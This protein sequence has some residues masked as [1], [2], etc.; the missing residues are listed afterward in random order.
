MSR[1]VIDLTSP[2]SA[3]PAGPRLHG[4]FFGRQGKGYAIS[5]AHLSIGERLGASRDGGEGYQVW[6]GALRRL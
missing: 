4:D 6:V 2:P 3:S 1:D 5:L